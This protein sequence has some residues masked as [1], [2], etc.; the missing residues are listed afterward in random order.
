MFPFNIF[1]KYKRKQ[2][3]QLKVSQVKSKGGKEPKTRHK[4]QSLTCSHTQESHTES[5]NIYTEDLVQTSVG[6]VLPGS[7]SMSS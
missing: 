5:Y 7:V 3:P 4:Y 1:K 2:E 6:P